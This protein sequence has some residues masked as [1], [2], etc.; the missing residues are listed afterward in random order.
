M[1]PDLFFNDELNAR[2]LD[3]FL[4]GRVAGAVQGAPLGWSTLDIQTVG[5]AYATVYAAQL[6]SGLR[7]QGVLL[8]PMDGNRLR[9]VTHYHVGPTDIERTL[10]AFRAVL[11]A[12]GLTA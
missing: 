9:A 12:N 10:A 6:A 4:T 8:S 1:P 3:W 5:G 2:E 11:S 7:E